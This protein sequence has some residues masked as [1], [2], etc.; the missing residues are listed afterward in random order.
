MA[1]PDSDLAPAEPIGMAV[2]TG[3][4]RQ[5]PGARLKAGERSCGSAILSCGHSPCG[6]Q[7]WWQVQGGQDEGSSVR[8]PSLGLGS[9]PATYRFTHYFVL[10]GIDMWTAGWSPMSWR[11][12]YLGVSLGLGFRHIPDLSST[13]SGKQY[14]RASSKMLFSGLELTVGPEE[15]QA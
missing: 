8:E 1:E 15:Q 2:L 7:R 3:A 4:R 14:G 5:A 11:C 12:P 10:C 6:S 9:S 13:C